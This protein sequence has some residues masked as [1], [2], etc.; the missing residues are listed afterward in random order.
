MILS[1]CMTCSLCKPCKEVGAKSCI[2]YSIYLK[3]DLLNV[4]NVS[5]QYC[6]YDRMPHDL[7]RRNF[8]QDEQCHDLKVNV[9]G[10]DFDD[11]LDTLELP[12]LD[13]ICCTT[14]DGSGCSQVCQRN[15]TIQ[16]DSE[17][18]LP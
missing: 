13:D 1:A 17:K 12:I 10:K 9:T 2:C 14:D 4:M 18:S 8:S 15:H 7:N 11:G 6:I 3:K 16:T 5:S